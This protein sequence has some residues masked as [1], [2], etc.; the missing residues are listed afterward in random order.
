MRSNPKISAKAIGEEIGITTLGVEKSISGLKKAG[1]IE[2]VGAAKGGH[3]ILKE[4]E[5]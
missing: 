4:P 5:E 3:W 2:R 1:I